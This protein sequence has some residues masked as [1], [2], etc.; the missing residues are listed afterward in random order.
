M[1]VQTQLTV[2]AEKHAHRDL[3]NE[4][5]ELDELTGVRVD[6]GLDPRARLVVLD[7]HDVRQCE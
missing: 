6:E 3:R 7:L 4:V 2:A 1:S 5:G